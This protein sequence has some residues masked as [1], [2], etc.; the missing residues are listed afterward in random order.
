MSLK[1]SLHKLLSLT[2][3]FCFFFFEL[4]ANSSN[5]NEK[6][7]NALFTYQKNNIVFSTNDSSNTISLEL[8]EKIYSRSKRDF[9][10]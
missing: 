8:N 9:E 6:I 2:I 10:I 1:I 7:N 4:F 3:L 5:N